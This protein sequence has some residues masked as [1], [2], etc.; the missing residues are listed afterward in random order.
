MVIFHSYVSLPEG[1]KQHDDMMSYYVR[2][3]LGIWK[4]I[5]K[6]CSDNCCCGYFECVN[7]Q[8]KINCSEETTCHTNLQI[9]FWFGYFRTI[10]HKHWGCKCINHTNVHTCTHRDRFAFGCAGGIRCCSK[11]NVSGSR[12]H[13]RH[14]PW[15]CHLPTSVVVTFHYKVDTFPAV[16]RCSALFAGLP[17]V[18]GVP[19]R[20]LAVALD[21]GWPSCIGGEPSKQWVGNEFFP[22]LG[23]E[24]YR[25]KFY[26]F[27]PTRT[28]LHTKHHHHHHHHHHHQ[29][30]LMWNGVIPSSYL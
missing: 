15:N 24:W 26:F 5:C 25:Y 12:S 21:V 30:Q 4:I 28:L 6:W 20:V 10:G 19:Y 11:N 3:Y 13:N 22:R 16:C 7:V 29:C 17:A 2:L 18:K 23:T 14:N 27:R 9:C 1:N 8:V